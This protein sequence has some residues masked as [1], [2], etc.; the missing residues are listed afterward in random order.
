ME[1]FIRGVPKRE[2]EKSL[3]DFFK[4]VLSRL[5]I[6][7]WICQ[8]IAQKPWAK[9]I[10]LNPQDG[11]RFLDLH[12]QTKNLAGRFCSIPGS[13]N[14]MFKGTPLYCS[15]SDRVDKF[16][17][18]SLKMDKQAKAEQKLTSAKSD[19]SRSG[20]DHRTLSCTSISCGLWDY[21][22]SELIFKPYFTL[23]ES[24]T[25]TFNAKFIVFKMDTSQRLDISYYGIEA[26]AWEGQPIP[27]IV[28]TLRE[29]P[30]FF[31]NRDPTISTPSTALPND[32][33]SMLQSLFR[34][35][36]QFA[37][38]PD[39]NRLTALNRDHQKIAGSC[40]VYRLLLTE[41]NRLH[42][43][44]RRL[45]QI[46]GMPPM[47]RR[48][49]NVRQPKEP[50]ASEFSRLLHL[51]SPETTTLPFAI[52]FQ[53]QKLAQN[54]YLPPSKVI[55]LLP[56][57]E[58][59][60]SQSDRRVCVNA[61]RKLFL[62]I[63]FAGPDTEPSNFKLQ[64]LVDLLRK[65]EQL[66]TREALYLEEPVGSENAAVIHKATVTPAGVYLSGPDLEGNNRV[67]R[68]YSTHHDYF[69]RVQFSDE[70]YLPV[71]FNPGASN[72]PIFDRFRKIL[73]EGL[74]IAGLHFSFLGFSHSSLRAQSC[75]FMAPFIHNGSLLYD[76]EV[77]KG[78]GNF[79]KIRS[80]ARCAARIGQAFS[81]TRDAIAL[82]PG[83]VKE[84]EDVKRDGR[85]F[86]DGVGTISKEA[87]EQIWDG[88]LAG[89]KK[90][91]T[92]LQIRYQG[93]YDYCVNVTT[94]DMLRI[95]S[96]VS[97]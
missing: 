58:N 56:E 48:H 84:M 20:K 69:L 92:V 49:I 12:G 39:R 75:W 62:Q 37:R 94:V 33:A 28:F 65:N 71:F 25:I 4:D 43:R 29:A 91:P 67:L 95:S 50:Y 93:K 35:H 31:Q 54:G 72:K 15:L 86:S 46:R 64:N 3:N 17:L 10:F 30:R 9:I 87:L 36:D 21:V 40:L 73:I 60:F 8:K 19:V 44:I 66:S 1:I 74:H 82:D 59:M 77:I 85:T 70:D 52:K 11:L 7:D 32:L 13:T 41:S 79:S 45:G 89:K 22:E 61:I 47:I 68:K 14:L 18:E 5:Q 55:A 2:T 42:D 53:L 38:G 23:T 6:E 81:D 90:K 78:L 16:A 57:V 34:N 97:S 26:V 76:R 83:V 80:P 24:A 63:P 88:L 96:A 27:A 51:L